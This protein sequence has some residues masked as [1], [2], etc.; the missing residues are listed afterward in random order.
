MA[1][2]QRGRGTTEPLTEEIKRNR[3]QKAKNKIHHKGRKYSELMCKNCI[4]VNWDTKST[5]RSCGQSLADSMRVTP[6]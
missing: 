5:C 4:S 1:Q 2:V 6:G 3:W